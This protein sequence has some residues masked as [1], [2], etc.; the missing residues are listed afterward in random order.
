MNADLKKDEVYSLYD[1]K[2]VTA[3]LDIRNNAAHGKYDAY[4]NEDVERF[5]DWLSDFIDRFPA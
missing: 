1:Q 4:N 5:I 2:M 3:Q